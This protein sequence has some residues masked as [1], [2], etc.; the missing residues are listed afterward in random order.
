MPRRDFSLHDY[1]EEHDVASS[2]SGTATGQCG[3]PVVIWLIVVEI[4]YVFG[5]RYCCVLMESVLRVGQKAANTADRKALHRPISA[6]SSRGPCTT[7]DNL[8][9][10]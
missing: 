1:Q 9:V 3:L 8:E 7:W 4:L 2:E 5:T 10:K 6:L